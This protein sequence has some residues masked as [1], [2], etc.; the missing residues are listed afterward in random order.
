MP[1]LGASLHMNWSGREESSSDH[2]N[3]KKQ[4]AG[5]HNDKEIKILMREIGLEV[6]IQK[7]EEKVHKQVC[8]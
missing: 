2:G 4:S 6:S 5:S 8:L 3:L 1:L 7:E